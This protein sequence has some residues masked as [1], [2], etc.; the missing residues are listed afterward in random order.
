[1]RAVT[2]PPH[3]A[4][5]CLDPEIKQQESRFVVPADLDLLRYVF[6][7]F[8]LTWDQVVPKQGTGLNRQYVAA[9]MAAYGQPA[10]LA[11]IICL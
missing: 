1:M 9:S 5:F 3:A 6:N 7:R 10:Y 2:L 8:V 4:I 11:T